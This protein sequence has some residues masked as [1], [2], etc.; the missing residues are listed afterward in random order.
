MAAA[1]PVAAKPAPAAKPEPPLSV[2]QTMARLPEPQPISQEA[3]AT[4]RN[5][6]RVEEP[7][8]E[9][10]TLPEPRPAKPQRAN[11]SG[12]VTGA[13]P[14]AEPAA[15]PASTAA[16][17]PAPRIRPVGPAEEA[18]RVERQLSTRRSEVESL[19]AQL[20][21]PE[22]RTETARVRSFM[23]LA[24]QAMARG[25]FVQ[26]DA[27]STRALTLARELTRAR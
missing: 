1:K 9:I 18:Q 7:G 12:A 13:A 8:E 22:I 16:E 25:D 4:L 20:K 2:P 6:P 17:T 10:E 27:L 21:Q 19:L 26:A 3:L 14:I 24:E 15:P 23:E 11:G 5:A